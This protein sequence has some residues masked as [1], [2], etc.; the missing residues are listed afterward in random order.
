MEA[1]TIVVMLGLSFYEVFLI[2]VVFCSLSKLK[3]GKAE[4][5]IYVVI[6]AVFHSALMYLFAN[7]L[8][9]HLMIPSHIVSILYFTALGYKKT[10]IVQLSAFYAVFIW[11]ILLISNLALVSFFVL[12]GFV[13]TFDMR[14]YHQA[15]LHLTFVYIAIVVFSFLFSYLFGNLLK[16]KMNGLDLAM[17]KKCANYLLG[18]AFIVLFFMYYYVFFRWGLS[19]EILGIIFLAMMGVLIASFIFAI[20]M[21]TNTVKSALN[22][23]QKEYYFTQCQLMQ[24]SVE[25]IKSI[26]HDMKLHMATVRGYATKINADQI[27]DYINNLLED[28]GESEI[29]SNTGNISVDSIINYKLKNAK[30]EGIKLQT[31]LI[32]PTDL[33]VDAADIATILGNLLDNALE[34]VATTA[35]NKEK[36]IKLDIEFSKESLFIQVDN[37]FDGIVKYNEEHII[38]RKDEENHGHGLK[39]I[40]QAVEKYDGYMDIAHEGGSFSVTILM[41]MKRRRGV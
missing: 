27:T 10:K 35:Q 20:S 12:I 15:F 4:L 33:N 28:I 16:N 26:R 40:K 34:A 3:F 30:Q 24:E 2:F 25:Q 13:S 32:I 29:H 9:T 31:R 5:A 18:S 39:N 8:S 22:A 14:V 11:V 23:Q 38:T 37:T 21:F 41:I 19:E 17:T 7:Y 36:E 6:Y 1:N